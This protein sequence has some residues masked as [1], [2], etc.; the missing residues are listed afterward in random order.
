MKK[1]AVVLRRCGLPYD[2][3]SAARARRHVE[4]FVA[5]QSLDGTTNALVLITSELVSNAVLHGSE[6]VELTLRREGSGVTVEVSD[7][8]PAVDNVRSPAANDRMHGGIGLFLIAALA[9]GW[10]I[11]PS[12]AGKTVWATVHT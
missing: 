12:R 5:E 8:D 1:T 4:R 2:P 10:G 6:P 3:R 9:D 11:R 7:G